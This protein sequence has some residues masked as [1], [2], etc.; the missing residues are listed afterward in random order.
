MAHVQGIEGS[1]LELQHLAV[2]GDGDGGRAR[3]AGERGDRPEEPSL[4]Q[5]G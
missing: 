2:G 5:R 3:P 1:P 4:L